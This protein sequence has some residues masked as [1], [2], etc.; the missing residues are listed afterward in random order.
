MWR[1]SELGGACALVSSRQ[2]QRSMILVPSC[3]PVACG[4]SYTCY[5]LVPV[6]FPVNTT[7]ELLS[8]LFLLHIPVLSIDKCCN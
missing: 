2:S 4:S 5:S 8:V 7:V 3:T 6:L 1:C